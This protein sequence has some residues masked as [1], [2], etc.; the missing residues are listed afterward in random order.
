MRRLPVEWGA[1]RRL[2]FRRLQRA[3]AFPVTTQIFGRPIRLHGDNTSERK[4]LVQPRAYN[5]RDF[6]FLTR[7][8]P[9]TGGTFVDI[10]ANAGV[11]SFAVAA[12][13]G[14]GS[15]ILCVE[16]NPAMAARIEIN[17]QHLNDFGGEGVRVLV[18]CRAVGEGNG[19]ARLAVDRGP[20]A[21]GLT[22]DPSGM[23]V[24]V[25]D[26]GSILDDHGMEQV[27]ALKIDIEGF[28]DRALLPFFETAP[29]SRWPRAMVVEHCSRDGWQTDLVGA[30][31]QR[32]YTV[33][34][35]TRNNLFLTWRD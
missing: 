26:L 30:L 3:G 6:S 21:A 12:H 18:D 11:Y 33:R 15:C 35:R 19:D 29:A 7:A 1:G 13:A 24:P 17:L 34:G 8:M 10:G 23:T 9:E 25:A 27:D 4:F 2:V 16:P 28:E 32:G 5:R 14:E 31:G 20:G 22:T